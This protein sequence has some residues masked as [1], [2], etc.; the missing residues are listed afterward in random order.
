M[1]KI[2]TLGSVNLAA[3]AIVATV[4]FAGTGTRK[5][6]D[7]ALETAV[8]SALFNDSYGSLVKGEGQAQEIVA[9]KL[10]GLV[11]STKELVVPTKAPRKPRAKKPTTA[12]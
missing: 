6:G 9:D 5:L 2:T 3:K 10:I 4:G 12:K 1:D 8:G 7:K 11:S